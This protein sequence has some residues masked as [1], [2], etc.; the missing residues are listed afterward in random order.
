MQSF[1]ESPTCWH[2]TTS[3]VARTGHAAALVGVGIPV[4]LGSCLGNDLVGSGAACPAVAQMRG[5]SAVAVTSV[6]GGF[7]RFAP[8][9]VLVVGD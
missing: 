3:L 4:Q 5:I 9:R 2:F 8:E 1:T 7:R 6:A